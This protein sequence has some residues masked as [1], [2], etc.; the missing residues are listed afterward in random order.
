MCDSHLNENEKLEDDFKKSLDQ[1]KIST[2][3][4]FFFFSPMFVTQPKTSLQPNI[5]GGP[6][7]V[8]VVHQEDELH[9]VEETTGALDN[10]SCNA[11]GDKPMRPLQ[12]QSHARDK[13]WRA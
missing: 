11:Q 7:A 12:L 5:Q 3:A 6:K 8:A 10:V 9:V 1:K 13:V 2:S 4:K